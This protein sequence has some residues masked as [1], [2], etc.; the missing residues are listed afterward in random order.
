[1]LIKSRSSKNYD[2]SGMGLTSTRDDYHNDNM[3]MRLWDFYVLKGFLFL[4]GFYG[5]VFPINR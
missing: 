4:F 3:A 5:K 1:M 2:L